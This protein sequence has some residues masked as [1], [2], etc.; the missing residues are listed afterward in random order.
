[1]R[2]PD[3]QLSFDELNKL[4]SEQANERSMPYDQF[5]G[6]MDLSQEQIERRKETAKRIEKFM[7]PAL[8]LMWY[9]RQEGVFDYMEATNEMLQPYE[10]LLKELGIPLT[11]FFATT[12]TQTTVSELV[13][14]TLE[15][16]DDAYF[17]SIDRAILV[18]ENEANSIWNDSEF[19]DAIN[20]GRTMKEWSAIIDKRTR[21]THRAAN[22]Q[23]VPITEPFLVGESLLQYARDT[24]LG[25][26]M[27]EIANCR[28]SVIYS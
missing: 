23:R 16:Q 9:M 7:I 17:Y 11:A 13:M 15:H 27:D 6:E 1:M 4:Y 10:N 28:C 25:A 26:S 14:S 19:Q 5:F 2:I 22:G 18:A 21:E 8:M 12:H 3:G 24:S 20:A